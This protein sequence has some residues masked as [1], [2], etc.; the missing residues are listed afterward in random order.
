[1]RG[2]RYVKSWSIL[3]TCHLACATTSVASQLSPQQHRPR[4]AVGKLAQ[5]AHL[6]LSPPVAAIRRSAGRPTGLARWLRPNGSALR[7]IPQL[8][9]WI[10]RVRA[11]IPCYSLFR[12]IHSLL[13]RKQIPVRI[14]QGIWVQQTEIAA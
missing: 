9:R 2:R 10:A 6:G 8:V 4:S 3:R 11:A 7:F 12:Q 5:N 13:G 14:E 1:M